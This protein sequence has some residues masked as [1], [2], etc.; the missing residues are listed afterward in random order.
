MA[1]HAHGI[2]EE[3]NYHPGL[4]ATTGHAPTLHIRQPCRIVPGCRNAEENDPLQVVSLRAPYVLSSVSGDAWKNDT[5]S[6]FPSVAE[7]KS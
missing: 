7:T 4:E 3:I 6:N 2:E 5:S 1:L